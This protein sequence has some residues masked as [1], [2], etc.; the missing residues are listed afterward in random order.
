MP[1]VLKVRRKPGLADLPMPRYMSAHAAGLDLVAAN[2]AP[3]TIAPGEIK[4][5]PTGLFL[6]IP[7]GYEGQVRARS[8]LALRHGLMLPN[9][10]GTIDA[11][12][13]GE[14]QVILGNCGR[15]PYTI[16]RGM[17]FAQLVIA[18]VAHAEVLEVEELGA[19]ERGGGGFGHTGV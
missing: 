4:L 15:A 18:A 16:E 8:G 2:D 11:D 6:E 1:P 19:S 3:I 14:L 17:R 10:P 7:P 9:A 13:R 5:V 12:Y